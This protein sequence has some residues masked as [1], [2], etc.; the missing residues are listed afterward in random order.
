MLK[1]GFDILLSVVMLSMA[2]P[3]FLVT[4]VIIK[5][6]SPGPIF[7][8]GRRVGR[9]GKPFHICKFRTMVV[10]ADQI[11]GSSTSDD[12]PRITKIGNFLRK[13]KLDELPQLFNV[14]T[15]TMSFVG[16]RPEVEEYVAMYTEEEKLILTLRPGIT[17]WASI[18]NSDEGAILAGSE[19]PD[20]AYLEIIRPTKLK[21]QLR[22][23]RQHSVWV[24]CK[25]IAYTAF[26][27]L[28]KDWLP[29][30]IAAYGRLQVG[31][32]NSLRKKAA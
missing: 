24:D 10:N 1:R 12:D 15:G 14:L 30:E 6:T 31:A 8:R 26:K 5:R 27:L 7:Y 11:G 19:D 9:H 16:P 22:Y 4:A 20:R 2:L 25:I 32:A 3:A 29:R 18:W 28:K 17:D 13:Y 23:A 21:L